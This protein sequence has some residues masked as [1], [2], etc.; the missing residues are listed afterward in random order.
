MRIICYGFV[1]NF[2]GSAM[3]EYRGGCHIDEKCSS[4]N[5][6]TPKL[7]EDPRLKI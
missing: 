5:T 1:K 2:I 6:F 3:T 7:N 4:E